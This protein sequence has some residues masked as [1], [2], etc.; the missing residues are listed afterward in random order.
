[1]ALGTRA[2]RI[3]RIRRELPILEELEEYTQQVYADDLF[4]S[5]EGWDA[6]PLWLATPFSHHRDSELLDECNWEVLSENLSVKFPSTVKEMR[7]GDWGHGWYERI[8][9]RIDD[10]VALREVQ[11]FIGALSDSGVLD[12]ERYSEAE[13]K[14]LKE[15]I[16]SQLG[17]YPGD[18]DDE[19]CAQVKQY[20]FEAH[21]VSRVD[22]VDQ[23][24]IKEA[25][26][27]VPHPYDRWDYG[28]GEACFYCDQ[29]LSA[30]CHPQHP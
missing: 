4:T 30:P 28:D 7:F 9:V 25:I 22:D 14:E 12:D 15:Y 17:G 23:A 13:T 20:L 29:E 8:Y 1:M 3:K 18:D 2:R 19:Y 11:N 27:T 10:A 21:S 26:R 24:M 6:T 16:S 5:Q